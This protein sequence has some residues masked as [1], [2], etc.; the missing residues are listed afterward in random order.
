MPM[1]IDNDYTEYLIR[2]GQDVQLGKVALEQLDKFRGHLFGDIARDIKMTGFDY[3]ALQYDILKRANKDQL[4]RWLE[5]LLF[6]FSNHAL[7]LLAEL[8]QGA[9]RVEELKEA[10][11]NDQAAIIDLQNQLIVAKDEQVQTLKSAVQSEV[12]TV[13]DEVKTFSSVL[14]QELKTQSS[15]IQKNVANVMCVK[16]VVEKEERGRNLVLYGV[17]EDES[18][19]LEKKVEDI[20]HHVGQKPRIVDCCRLG[21]VQEGTTRPVK[22][23]LPS[24]ATAFEVLRNSKLLKSAEGCQKI[25]VHPDRTVEQRK[26]Q[27]ELVTQLREMRMKNTGVRYHIRN[28]KVVPR[29]GS[30]P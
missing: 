17:P 4:C 14:Q 29:D 23:T 3:N 25:F 5:T 30:V 12:K 2:T 6:V 16:Q 11:I 9:E 7:P 8:S 26:A 10:K 20:L 22:V 27:K 1:P 24:S 13:Q 18:Q 15:A 28:G 19:Q 21:R